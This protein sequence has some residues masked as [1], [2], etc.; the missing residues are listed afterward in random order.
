M[1]MGS[2]NGDG[3][4]ERGRVS[5]ATSSDKRERPM[6]DAR[7][8]PTEIGCLVDEPQ[9]FVTP[10][11]A[12]YQSLLIGKGFGDYDGQTFYMATRTRR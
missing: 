4:K 6:L 10:R 9:E 12:A 7:D 11:T 1:M 5:A 8:F 3:L 2:K